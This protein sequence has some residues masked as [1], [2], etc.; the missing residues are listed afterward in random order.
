M[1][2]MIKTIKDEYKGNALYFDAG[3]QFQ[4]EI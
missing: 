1:A 2:H 3:D 4:G